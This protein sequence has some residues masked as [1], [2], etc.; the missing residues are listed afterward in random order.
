[1]TKLLKLGPNRVRRYTKAQG[2][3]L[4][5][6]INLNSAPCFVQR[7]CHGPHDRR[8][9]FVRTGVMDLAEI[10]QVELKKARRVG[11]EL[12]ESVRPVRSDKTVRVVRRRDHGNEDR[13]IGRKQRI[14]RP[15]GGVP[16]RCISIKTDGDEV[17]V[18]AQNP[19]VV[20]GQSSALGGNHV[21]HPG[22]VTGDQIELS[23]ADD[24]LFLVQHCPPGFIQSEKDLSFRENRSF[25]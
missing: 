23:F 2:S 7:L 22:H 15:D 5:V 21:F 4:R 6:R 8:S 3:F 10:I 25:R 20:C 12:F 24:C 16:P 14:Q 13:D 11:D 18:S 9:A 19:G 17:H 1:M